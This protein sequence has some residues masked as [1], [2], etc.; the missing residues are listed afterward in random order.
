MMNLMLLILA[1]CAIVTVLFP[2][3]RKPAAP[4]A[5]PAATFHPSPSVHGEGLGVR[6]APATT[7]DPYPLVPSHFQE[8]NSAAACAALQ[9]MLDS[10]AVSLPIHHD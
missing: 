2:P 5:A 6:S 9:A 4:A 7:A 1:C 10:G 3:K 8:G